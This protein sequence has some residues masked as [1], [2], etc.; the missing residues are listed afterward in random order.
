MK[1]NK[2][3]QILLL[4]LVCLIWGTVGY[5]FMNFETEPN[6]TIPQ[7][8][9]IIS[10]KSSVENLSFSLDLNYADPFLKRASPTFKVNKSIS[11]KKSKRRKVTPKSSG[12]KMPKITYSGYSTDSKNITRARLKLGNKTYTIRKNET[13]EGVILSEIHKDSVVVFFNGERATINR[14]N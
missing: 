14:Q 8:A 1:D 9:S 3:T 5:K 10:D 13:K 4:V 11:Q 7:K 2:K 6:F 12:K